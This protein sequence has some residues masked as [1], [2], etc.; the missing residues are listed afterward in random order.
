M[1]TKIQFVTVYSFFLLFIIQM[2]GLMR[3]DIHTNNLLFEGGI[4]TGLINQTAPSE[5]DTD[6][7]SVW[8]NIGFFL[9][10]MSVSSSFG[11]FGTLVL[12]PFI[13]GMTFIIAEILKDLIPFT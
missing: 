13:I 4:D 5:T 11:L 12:T 2:V 7:F 9:T 6:K 10:L 3:A 8:D 1:V